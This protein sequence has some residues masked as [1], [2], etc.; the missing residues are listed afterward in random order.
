ME[1]TA[2]REVDLYEKITG[3]LKKANYN[4]TPQSLNPNDQTPLERIKEGWGDAVHIVG[5]QAEKGLFGKGPDTYTRVTSSRNPNDLALERAKK[6][7][8]RKEAA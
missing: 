2:Q 7:I 3:S 6:V 1:T 5:N 4:V 8:T